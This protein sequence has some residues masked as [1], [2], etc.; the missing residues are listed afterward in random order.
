MPGLE[1]SQAEYRRPDGPGTFRG[2][3]V[4]EVRDQPLRI[5][6]DGLRWGLVAAAGPSAAEAFAREHGIRPRLTLTRADLLKGPV[7]LRDAVRGAEVNAV[8]V[9][10]DDWRRQGSPQLYE[11]ALGLI[12]AKQRVIVDEAAGTMHRLGRVAVGARVATHPL[13]MAQAGG[14]I[15]AEAL[16]FSL[17]RRRRLGTQTSRGSTSVLAIWPG[18]GGS[19]GGAISHITGIL[20]AFRRAGLRVGLVTA[21]PPPEQ[22]RAAIDY[23]EVCPHL[24]PSARMT[25]DTAAMVLNRPVREAATALAQRLHPS[26]IYQRHCLFMYAGVELSRRW[27]IPLVLEWNGSEVWTR[28]NWGRKLAIERVLDPVAVAVEGAALASA[29]MVAGV[30]EEAVDMA[31]KA[32]ATRGNTIVVPNA[33]DLE[34]VDASLKGSIGSSAGRTG[35]VIGWAGSFGSWHGGEMIVRALSNLP[36]DV[37]L[38][39]IGEGSERA[40][41]QALGERLGLAN[42]IEWTGVIPHREALRRLSACDVLVSPQT[43]LPGQAYFMSPIK[44][45][46]Y[47]ALGRPIV[48]SRL[49]Q[50]GEM[51]VDGVTARLVTPGDVQ[52]LS[53]AILEVLRSA[54]RGQALAEAARQEVETSHTWDHRAQVVLERLAM[55]LSE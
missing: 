36:S 7:A 26:F 6:A 22:V 50:M 30:S 35:A 4:S 33:V 29:A 46:E 32:G 13:Q 41:C 34:Y 18:T 21:S 19:V 37:R 54:D 47:M 45:F 27:G 49:G 48:A 20:A 3:I 16:R 51:L 42:R 9:H 53:S 31:V 25:G 39:M 1:H 52:E 10:S 15:T 2:R 5:D 17:T 28:N 12:P 23:L 40:P 24:P 43:P 55:D 38:L 11:F 44:V 8:I 14:A